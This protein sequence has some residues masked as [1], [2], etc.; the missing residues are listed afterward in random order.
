MKNLLRKMRKNW[1]S[2][3]AIFLLLLAIAA[4]ANYYLKETSLIIGHKTTDFKGTFLE[5]LAFQHAFL[6]F[7]PPL[8]IILLV[9]DKWHNKF[10]NG[11]IKNYLTRMSY[12]QLKKEM[13]ISIGKIS[14]IYPLILLIFLLISFILTKGAN[15]GIDLNQFSGY[16]DKWN[17]QNFPLYLIKMT[18][19]LYIQGLIISLYTFLYLN[20][21]RNK[22]LLI[23]FTYI[24]W[25]ISLLAIQLVPQMILDIYF[26]YKINSDYLNFYMIKLYTN[27]TT[28]FFLYL[29][30]IT[31]FTSIMFAI[32]YFVIYKSK[33]K[34][35]LA[36]EKEMV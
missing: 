16:Y 31:L 24:T 2:I 12:K 27:S 22:V 36:N 7:L 11:N 28:N 32:N 3:V 20:K 35:V 17:Y 1:L 14:L 15:E 34:V 6:F 5:M 29:L 4:S 26:N 23:L 33:E 21:V 19:L 9:I 10:K 13:F 18:I 8:S 30:S 25:L